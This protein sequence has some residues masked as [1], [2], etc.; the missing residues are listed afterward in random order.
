MLIQDLRI[1]NT[2]MQ[3]DA[4]FDLWLRSIS[5]VQ[6]Y[7]STHGITELG[8]TLLVITERVLVNFRRMDE[9]AHSKEKVFHSLNTDGIPVM[10]DSLVKYQGD[11]RIEALNWV[12]NL[13]DQTHMLTMSVHSRSLIALIDSKRGKRHVECINATVLN[14]IYRIAQELKK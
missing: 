10:L 13:M 9:L 5:L 3:K 6:R 14:T 11:D 12:E 2:A 8:D 1:W 7:A 4:A